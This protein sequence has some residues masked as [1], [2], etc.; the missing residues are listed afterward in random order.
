M[1]K[2]LRME[3]ISYRTWMENNKKGVNGGRL[4]KYFACLMVAHKDADYEE[5]GVDEFEEEL[6]EEDWN[7]TSLFVPLLD[8]NVKVEEW[9]C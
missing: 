3:L 4:K 5:E 9:G 1:E 2:N 7:T 8:I 6:E